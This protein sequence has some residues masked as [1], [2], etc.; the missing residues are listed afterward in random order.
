MSHKGNEV[1]KGVSKNNLAIF[2]VTESMI[3]GVAFIHLIT[4]DHME[5]T[6]QFAIEGAF[7]SKFEYIST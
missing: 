5:A 3:T 2:E 6:V 4:L 7:C 1:H